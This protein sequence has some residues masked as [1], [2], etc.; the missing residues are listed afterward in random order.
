MTRARRL[1]PFGV[2]MSPKSHGHDEADRS[3]ARV[4]DRTRNLELLGRDVTI[5]IQEH[6]NAH[7]GTFH[8]FIGRNPAHCDLCYRARRDP[9]HR[10]SPPKGG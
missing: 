9:P 6:Y 4:E 1:P 7:A 10:T 2:F 8:R 5:A 3:T